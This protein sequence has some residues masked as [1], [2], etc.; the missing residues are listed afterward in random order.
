MFLKKD[1][2]KWKIH[3]FFAGLL[4]VAFGFEFMIGL[5]A[6]SAV[7]VAALQAF[8]QVNLFLLLFHLSFWY[9]FATD[10]VGT[11]GELKSHSVTLNLNDKEN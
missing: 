3:L 9:L 4:L 11:D 6:G 8:K 5:L 10:R 1:T 2:P 7:K